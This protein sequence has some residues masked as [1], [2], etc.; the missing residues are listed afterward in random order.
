MSRL[1]GATA[2]MTSMP[3]DNLSTHSDPTESMDEE[4]EDDD[5]TVVSSNLSTDADQTTASIWD[6]AD[7][8]P[9]T[10]SYCQAAAIPPPAPLARAL[11]QAP[12]TTTKLTMLSS[13]PGRG[14]GITLS[15]RKPQAAPSL[16]MK[17]I[18]RISGRGAAGA[19]IPPKKRQRMTRVS[20]LK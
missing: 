16:T 10:A 14:G 3:Q 18:S 1:S 5:T 13:G 8:P 15:A 2:G 19:P 12:I 4:N 17:A 20:C 7:F 11:F 6:A 9:P